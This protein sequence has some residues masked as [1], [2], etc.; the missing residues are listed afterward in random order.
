MIVIQEYIPPSPED[1]YDALF[2]TEKHLNMEEMQ[3][4]MKVFDGLGTVSSLFDYTY[5]SNNR[6]V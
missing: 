1:N 2:I 4:Y 3:K 5:H 6:S